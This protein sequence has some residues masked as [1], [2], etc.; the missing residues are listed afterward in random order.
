MIRSLPGKG[1]TVANPPPPRTFSVYVFA[2]D[3]RVGKRA[4]VRRL[5]P[6]ADPTKPVVSVGQTGKTP[7]ER[8]QEHRTGIRSGKYYRPDDCLH[9]LPE[10]YKRLNRMTELQSLRMER[11]LAYW[12]RKEGYT[13]LGG[14]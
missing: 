3:S 6:D 4:P 11:G 10:L 13:A 7:E 2:L 14:H 12:L 1:H 8:F 5:N 9:L